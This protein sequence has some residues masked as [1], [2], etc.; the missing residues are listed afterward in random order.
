MTSTAISAQGSTLAVNT[1]TGSGITITGISVGYPTII[2]ATGLNNG[3]VVALAGLGGADSGLLNGN[4]YPV[5]FS[6]GS[7]F[8][9]AVDTTGKTIT[10]SGTATPQTYTPIANVK[11]FS[12]F[13]GKAAIIDVTNLSST[14]KEKLVGIQDFGKFSFDIHV[15]YSDAGQLALSAAKAAATK[16]TFKLT[17]P[18]AKVATFSAFVMGMPSQGAVDAV[19]AGSVELEITGAVV[20][21]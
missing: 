18:N 17:Y 9:V 16:K 2:T 21:A 7:K 15:D 10:A 4:S 11:S 19:V 14:A 8:S 5:L 3:D 20:V 13:D 6:T 1:G 12:G